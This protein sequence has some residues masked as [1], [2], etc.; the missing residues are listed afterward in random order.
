MHPTQLRH[1]ND[2][3]DL[4]GCEIDAGYLFFVLQIMKP[5]IILICQAFEMVPCVGAD[6]ARAWSHRHKDGTGHQ[7]NYTKCDV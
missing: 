3:K 6:Y 5:S 7:N 2:Q 4:M 1:I